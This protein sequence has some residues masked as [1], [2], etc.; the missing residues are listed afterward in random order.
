L[1]AE[2]LLLGV[3]QGLVHSQAASGKQD[4]RTRGW[5]MALLQG[6]GMPDV[7]VSLE[8]LTM[9]QQSKWTDAGVQVLLLLRLF[10]ASAVNHP[11]WM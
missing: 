6:E 9:L 11:L 3:C 10:H 2:L 4:M 1:V 8:L 7:S 5:V